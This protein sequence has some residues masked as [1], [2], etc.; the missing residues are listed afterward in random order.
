MSTEQQSLDLSN[1]YFIKY[2]ESKKSYRIDKLAKIEGLKQKK[3]E[4]LSKE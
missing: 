1:H 2:L 4:E 3:P